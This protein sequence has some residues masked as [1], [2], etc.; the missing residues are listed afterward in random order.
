MRTGMRTYA[1]VFLFFLGAQH[2]HHLTPFQARVLFD[3]RQFSQIP[4]YTYEEFST[5]VLVCHLSATET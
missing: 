4:L 2:H 1:A 5:E 3:D